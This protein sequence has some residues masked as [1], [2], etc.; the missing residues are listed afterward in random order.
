MITLD[1]KLM[2]EVEQRYG[3]SLLEDDPQQSGSGEVHIGNYLGAVAPFLELQKKAEKMYFFI[4]DLHALTTVQNKEELQRN[5]ENLVLSY[6]AFGIDTK[7]VVFYR[8][9]DIPQHTELQSILNN[10]TPLPLIKRAHAYKDKLQKGADLEEINMGLF[11]YPVLMA[12][13]ILLYDPDYVP[14]GDDQKQHI[15]ITR[16]IA[17]FFNNAY[18]NTFILPD[19]YNIKESARLVGTDGKR[20]MSKS[21]NNYI[22]V[23]A[24]EKIIKK[25]VMSCYTDPNRKKVTDHGQVE[26]NPVFTYH[27]LLNDNKDE[28][29]DLEN[30]YTSGTVSDVEVKEKLIQA[31]L[32]KF[33]KERELY[34]ELRANPEK[35]RIILNE[36]AEKARTQ[37][38]K[39]MLE[40]REKIGITNK[41]SQFQY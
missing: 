16:D 4:A 11:S 13:D 3:L 26:G 31:I 36:G 25:Q 39:K 38:K 34:N 10:V 19:I 17:G 1:T 27:R 8:Q 5:V 35:I 24:D 20:K 9:S 15:E 32:S 12:A 28:V 40:V 7:K 30:R 6:L 29:A 37:A 41:Y 2:E 33:K 18:G 21:L 22:A 14:V 23:F